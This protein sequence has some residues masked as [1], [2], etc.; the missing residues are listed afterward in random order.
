M[1]AYCF[2]Y[3]LAVVMRATDFAVVVARGTAGNRMLAQDSQDLSGA[4]YSCN[5]GW[6]CVVLFDDA[7]H[8]MPALR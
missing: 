4:A 8:D 3:C 1:R 7:S 6:L 2:G 5:W